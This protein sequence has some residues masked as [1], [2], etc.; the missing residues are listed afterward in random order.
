MTKEDVRLIFGNITEL[1]LFADMFCDCLEEALGDVLENG[2]GE[3]SVGALFLRIVSIFRCSFVSV[4]LT[5]LNRY[6]NWNR[7]TLITLPST[8][9]R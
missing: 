1:A 9:M 8:R 4:L 6:P 7:H 3:D 2:M 5:K